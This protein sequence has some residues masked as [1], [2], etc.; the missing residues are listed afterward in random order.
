MFQRL[1]EWPFRLVDADKLDIKLMNTMR[2]I[3]KN[4][5][6][7]FDEETH[8][9]IFRCTRDESRAYVG[10]FQEKILALYQQR[11]KQFGIDN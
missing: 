4:R 2:A 10:N 3:W 6:P 1:L 5:Y 11:L 7:D 9:R 8:A